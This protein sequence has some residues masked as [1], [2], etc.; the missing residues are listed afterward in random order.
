[1]GRFL[2]RFLYGFCLQRG[3]RTLQAALDISEAFALKRSDFSDVPASINPP[4]AGLFTWRKHPFLHEKIHVQLRRG[5][6]RVWSGTPPLRYRWKAS[7][8]APEKKGC[9][10]DLVGDS[11]VAWGGARNSKSLLRHFACC[12]I[13][14]P[15]SDKLYYGTASS[16]SSRTWNYAIILSSKLACGRRVRPLTAIF[17]TSELAA[18]RYGNTSKCR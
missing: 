16:R 10:R 1:M 12:V 5:R 3:Q 14:L 6:R 7:C 17:R 11:Q 8:D 18:A 9:R 4:K 13:T 15:K 2:E